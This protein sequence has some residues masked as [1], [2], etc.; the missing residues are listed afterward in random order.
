MNLG[1]Q[2]K[3]AL[4]L[5]SS[6]GLGKSV[7]IELAKEGAKVIICATD[8]VALSATEAEIQAIAPNHVASFICDITDEN[9]RRNLVE[10]SIRAFG[11]IEILVTRTAQ[12]F[13]SAMRLSRS[14]QVFHS[15]AR[16]FECLAKANLERRIWRSPTSCLC[17]RHQRHNISLH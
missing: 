5:A 2:N 4:I 13:R 12:V 15:T 8:A 7:A 17:K 9:Q 11:T 16:L 1:I 6:K 14:T 3:V 10:Q